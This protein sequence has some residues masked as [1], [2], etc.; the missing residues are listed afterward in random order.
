MTTSHSTEAEIKEIVRRLEDAWN[1]GDASAWVQDCLED[2]DFINIRGDVMPDREASEKRHAHMF[3]G[4]FR[5]SRI[6]FSI[7]RI[8]HLSADAAIVD[9][10]CRLAD[11]PAMPPGIQPTEPGVLCTRLKHVVVRRD[12]RW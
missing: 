3:A 5:G 9:T 12:G 7:R 2:T 8:R 10:D 4:P 11:A 1:A 6:V